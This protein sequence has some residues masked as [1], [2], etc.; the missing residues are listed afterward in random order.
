MAAESDEAA[1]TGKRNARCSRAN[2]PGTAVQT[3]VFDKVIWPRSFIDGFSP[4]GFSPHYQP[5]GSFPVFN[6]QMHAWRMTLFAQIGMLPEYLRFAMRINA[7]VCAVMLRRW[8]GN[9][10]LIS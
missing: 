10:W 2:I 1:I 3:G 9:H 8:C 5:T 4:E 6:K 7:G